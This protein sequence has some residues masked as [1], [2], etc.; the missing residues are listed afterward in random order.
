MNYKISSTCTEILRNAILSTY[1]CK[2][3]YFEIISWL[4]SLSSS[5]NVLI[6]SLTWSS[7]GNME[8]M[9]SGSM[10]KRSEESCTF[11]V[12]IK[13][14]TDRLREIQASYV[15]GPLLTVAIVIK[16]RRTTLERN[17]E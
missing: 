17:T 4:G 12:R 1:L 5:N 13:A 6:F 8:T 3:T 10:A 16:E 7:S 14:G 9:E 11:D 15:L 2:V